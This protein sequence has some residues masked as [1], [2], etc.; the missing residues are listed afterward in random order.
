MKKK[1]SITVDE[2]ILMRADSL[3]DRIKIKNR[4]QAIEQL[5]RDSLSK[6]K[7]TT[8]L[9]LVGGSREKLRFGRTYRPLAKVDGE[10][11]MLHNVKVLARHG[12]RQVVILGSFLLPEIEKILGDGKDIG[13]SIKYVDDKSSGTAGA[14]KAAKKFVSNDFFVIFGDIYFDFDLGKMASFHFSHPGL[15]TMAV[16]STKLD[17]SRDRLELEGD[18]VIS[19]EYVP[20]EKTHIVNAS[21]FILSHEIFQH[22]PQKGSMETDVFPKLSADG[23]IIAYNFSGKWRHIGSEK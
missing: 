5:L 16:T 20:R 12:I 4:S 10:E 11:T 2:E 21:I 1:I 9:I 23:K 18:K 7:I 13:M 14:I 8:A 17:K 6:S 15:V 22:M 19:F 3:I